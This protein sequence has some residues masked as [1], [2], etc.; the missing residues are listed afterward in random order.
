MRLQEI[1]VMENN[2]EKTF[3]IIKPEGIKNA[4]AIK[5][6]ILENGMTI[7]MS[8]LA[9]LTPDIIK[10][11]YTDTSNDLLKAHLMFMSKDISEVGIIEGANAINRLVQISG[12]HTNPNLCAAGT[13][14]N[15]FGEKTC[16]KVG[17]SLYYKNVIHRSLNKEEAD[18]DVKLFDRIK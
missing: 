9:I 13:I 4:E 5:N 7:I 10:L 16:S 15:L 3:F 6:I 2:F 18:R 14:R 12:S 11:I 8:K 1:K 17:V